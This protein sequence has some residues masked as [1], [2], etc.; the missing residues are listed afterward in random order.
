MVVAA[1][2]ERGFVRCRSPSEEVTAILPSAAL[3][4][5]TDSPWQPIERADN[6]FR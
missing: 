2:A 5:P 4:N 1:V 6:L 3:E